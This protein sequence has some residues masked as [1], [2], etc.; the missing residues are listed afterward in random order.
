MSWFDALEKRFGWFRIPHL[1][2][3]LVGAQ[4]LGFLLSMGRPDVFVRWALIPQRVLAGEVWRLLTFLA[5]PPT[6]NALFAFFALYLLYLFGTALEARWGE[7]RF[8]LYVAIGVVAT[9]AAAFLTPTVPATNAFISASI[10]LAFAT[11]YPDFQLLLFFILPVRVKWLAMLTGLG[12]AYVLAVGS[13]PARAMVGASVLAYLIFFAGAIVGRVRSGKRRMARQI[14][15]VKAQAQ[16]F[17]TCAVCG[18]TDKSHP[19]AEFRYCTDCVGSPG[20][21]LEHA[22]DH[23]HKTE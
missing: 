5:L 9:V 23:V 3:I 20:Y 16:P 13:W 14:A 7:F 22:R 10:F 6:L 1:T 4:A 15:D 18:I 8:T 21:C 2:A 12:Y 11:L 19:D 17:H